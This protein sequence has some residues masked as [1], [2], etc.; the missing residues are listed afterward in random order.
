[1]DRL[2]TAED[3]QDYAIIRHY[4]EGRI[5]G[6]E[7]IHFESDEERFKWDL[8]S[9]DAKFDPDCIAFVRIAISLLETPLLTV[10]EIA[11]TQSEPEKAIVGTIERKSGDASRDSRLVL[12]SA[13]TLHH[14]CD[15]GGCKMEPAV[16][17][18]TALVWL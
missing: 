10:G 5:R 18:S 9:V 7:R 17:S 13:L 11:E 12:I 1:M 3:R 16:L 8:E 2:P 15:K 6:D 14:D 4:L